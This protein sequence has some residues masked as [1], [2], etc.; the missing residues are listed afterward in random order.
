MPCCVQAGVLQLF[1]VDPAATRDAD[2]PCKPLATLTVEG[3]KV[4]S[5]LGIRWSI[6]SGLSVL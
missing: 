5:W 6:C 4:S 2:E 1:S 3:D